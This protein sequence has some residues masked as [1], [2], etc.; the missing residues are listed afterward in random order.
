M[1]VRIDF[2]TNSSSS[3]FTIPTDKL[4]KKQVSAIINHSELGEKI[5][6]E[7]SSEAWRIKVTDMMV[8][9]DTFMNNFDMGDFLDK[10]GVNRH[11]VTWDD[12]ERSYESYIPAEPVAEWES[13]L[14]ELIGGADKKNAENC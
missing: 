8:S 7:Y 5:G 3:S 4:S 1:K 2:V 10:I 13:I 11:L 6:I 9:A 12:F 14:D